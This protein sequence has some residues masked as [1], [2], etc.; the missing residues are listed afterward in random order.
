M[1]DN[2]GTMCMYTRGKLKKK[3]ERLKC[4]MIYMSAEYKV[5]LRIYVNKRVRF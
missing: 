3:R 4:T 5:C 1:M 2:A